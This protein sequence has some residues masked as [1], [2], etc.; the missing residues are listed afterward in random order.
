MDFTFGII[1]D[2][3]SEDFIGK[4]IDSIEKQE[5]PNYEIIIVGNSKVIRKNVKIYRFNESF[6]KGWITRKKNIICNL[7]KYENI[8][9]LHDY[10]CLSDNWYRGFLKY[11]NNFEFCVTQIKTL[12]GNRF[13]DYMLYSHGLDIYFQEN[14]LLPYEYEPSNDIRR[15]MYISGAYYII[16]KTVAE[17]YPLNEELLHTQGEDVEISQ[18]LAKNSVF[19]K[20]NRY[21]EVH[22]LKDKNHCP[23]E[24][25]ISTEAIQKL[26]CLSEKEISELF[27]R[28]TDHFH[29]WLLKTHNIVISK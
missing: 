3:N 28:Q 17:A 1:T 14:S 20:C 8:V 9:L 13:R 19:I 26:E 24:N 5:I 22:F 4:I 12:Q 10:V 23:W 25:N 7:A 18:R 16:K 2:G 29:I 21:S 6:R 11:G 15:F 27:N